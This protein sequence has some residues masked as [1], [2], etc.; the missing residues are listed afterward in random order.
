MEERLIVLKL[1]LDE[2]G[3]DPTISNMPDRKRIQK[4]VYLAQR[5]GLD[6]GYRFGWYIR[7]PYSPAL[8]RD[9]YELADGLRST[10]AAFDKFKLDE[11][12]K[13]RLDK[14]KT[15]MRPTESTELT[16][17]NWLE[18]VASL[19]YLRHVQGRPAREAKV[20]LAGYKPQL[21]SHVDEAEG[22]LEA[23]GLP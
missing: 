4:A 3:V 22:A 6:L 9:Y 14:V 1:V 17:P 23:A 7:G 12:V 16:Q 20:A 5:S 2:L 18:L 13:P 19:D 15:L 11:R 21:S 10:P 8:A